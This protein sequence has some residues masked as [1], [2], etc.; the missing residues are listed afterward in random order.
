M[1]YALISSSTRPGCQSGVL[2][3][4]QLRRDS[5]QLQCNQEP[6]GDHHGLVTTR[7]RA[8]AY[9]TLL[10]SGDQDSD[11]SLSVSRLLRLVPQQRPCLTS[12]AR[13]WTRARFCMLVKKSARGR[14]PPAGTLPTRDSVPVVD[15]SITGRQ[16]GSPQFSLLWKLQDFAFP[17]RACG[18]R[19]SITRFR[20]PSR[21][22]G[23]DGT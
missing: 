13:I 3:T 5:A 18:S 11:S 16:R 15:R 10:S 7:V 22:V 21:R 4:S 8:E 2:R 9:S 12:P 20:A 14:H 23:S 19:C 17:L 1:R 6:A